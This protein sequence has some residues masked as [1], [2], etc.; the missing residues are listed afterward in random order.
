MEKAA[1][2]SLDGTTLLD[3]N[4][5]VMCEVLSTVKESKEQQFAH[6]TTLGGSPGNP[7]AGHRP[8]PGLRQ[9]HGHGASAATSCSQTQLV[10]GP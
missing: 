3:V 9:V 6:V 8:W 5:R 4:E 7:T 2:E 1:T 10:L